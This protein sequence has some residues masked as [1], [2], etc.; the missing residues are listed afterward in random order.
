MPG[1]DHDGGV[2]FVAVAA[3]IVGVYGR[4]EKCGKR[5]I[6]GTMSCFTPYRA[7]GYM[8]VWKLVIAALVR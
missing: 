6:K 2:W 4:N 1:P 5:R 7:D 3:D 8:V